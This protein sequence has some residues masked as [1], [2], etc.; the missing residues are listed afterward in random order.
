MCWLE[1]EV[2]TFCITLVYSADDVICTATTNRSH[3]EVFGGVA[4]WKSDGPVS[5]GK[6]L[7]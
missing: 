3:S 4:K 5:G 1:S 6:R 7:S 2:V